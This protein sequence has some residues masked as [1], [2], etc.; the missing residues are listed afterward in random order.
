MIHSVSPN[1]GNPVT[2]WFLR[3]LL[4][5]SLFVTGYV[6]SYG[7]NSL[8]KYWLISLPVMTLYTLVQ[9]LRYMRD[10]DYP[11]YVY[12]L[13]QGLYSEYSEPIY[14][15]WANTFRILHIPFVWAFLFYSLIL[16][17]GFF[18]LLKNF[19]KAAV[20]ACPLFL[21][22]PQ[23]CT[24]LIRMFFAMA[25][26]LIAIHYL[27][28]QRKKAYLF[29]LVSCMIHFSVIP[30]VLI[31]LIL[32]WKKVG[33]LS[34]HFLIVLIAY[35]LIVCYWDIT[36]FDDLTMALSLMESTGFAQGDAYLE[37]ADAW[38]GTGGSI[39]AKYGFKTAGILMTTLNVCVPA[40]IMYYG[41]KAYKIEPK[42]K[43]IFGCTIFAFF[44]NQL[45]GDIELYQRYYHW[46]TC[47][48]P[49]LIGAIWYFVKMKFIERAIFVFLMCLYYY[50]ANFLNYLYQPSAVGYG[51]IWDI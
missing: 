49:I 44:I 14:I 17:F 41:N 22:I 5:L 36:I 21:V 48:I 10:W 13:T 42:L 46:A 24:N 27:I 8:K 15:F 40:Y 39:S 50:G 16:V 7:R 4:F 33:L 31:V 26:L 25:F 43:I 45:G 37:N 23:E 3:L 32:N 9:G 6:I 29:L 34:N 20:W 38:L 47:L 12:D 28:N 35:F 18:L 51:F 2:Y 1:L 19:H 30:F 11:H